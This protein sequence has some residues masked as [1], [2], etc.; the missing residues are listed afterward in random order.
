[1][2][3]LYE[4]MGDYVALQEAL[5]NEELTDKRL[6]ELLDAVDE[7]KGPL[8]EKVDNIARLIGSLKGDID[9]FKREE[10]RL[11]RRRKAL[12]NRRERLRDWVRGTMTLLDKAEVKTDV[13]MVKLLAAKDRVEVRDAAAVPDEYV[14]VER[15]VDKEAVM[16]AYV[17]DGEVVPG[18]EIV[19]GTA[20]LRIR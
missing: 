6:G 1:M 20:Q 15:K 9:K 13:Y 8:R 14:R 3:N 12:E 16:K 4:L 19:Q 18:C 7:A 2:P 17:D 11:S 5:D 10:N